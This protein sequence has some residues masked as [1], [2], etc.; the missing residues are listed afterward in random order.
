MGV[1]RRI[2]I[3]VQ[4]ENCQPQNALLSQA[5]AGEELWSIPKVPMTCQVLPNVGIVLYTIE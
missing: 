5:W 1:E 3:Q 2:D 4:A